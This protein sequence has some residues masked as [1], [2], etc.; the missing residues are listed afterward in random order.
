MKGFTPQIFCSIDGPNVSG[1]VSR[2]LIKATVTDGTG[3]ES[4]G[5][6]IEMDNARDEIDWPK[7]GSV[8]VF[9]GG[10]RETGGPRRMGT[11]SIEDAEKTGSLR[12]L[13]VIARAGAPG[14][15]IKEKRNRLSTRRQSR[16]SFR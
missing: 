10:Y 8:L 15:K 2:R 14:D 11:Y 12:Q 6:T 9:G 3:I 4:D 7:K 16:T 1:L 13:T 5:I